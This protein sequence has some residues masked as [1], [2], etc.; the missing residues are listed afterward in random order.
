M[1]NKTAVTLTF[2]PN[3]SDFLDLWKSNPIRYLAWVLIILAAVYLYWALDIFVNY[4][5][6]EET[7]STIVS[8]CGVAM[9]AVF[10]AFALPRL[11]ARITFRGRVFRE[12]RTMSV[13]EEGVGCES[14]LFSGIYRWDAFT[15]VRETKRSFHFYVSPVVAVF[16]PKR[17]LPETEQVSRLRH[18]I[19]RSFKGK[20][21]LRSA[22]A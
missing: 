10:G 5:Y 7:A 2:Q 15:S 22:A 4:G 16:I 11:R 19:Q 17:S 3:V 14:Q 12:P 21:Y 18:I 8:Y 6:T 20:T 9:F 13:T 1:D